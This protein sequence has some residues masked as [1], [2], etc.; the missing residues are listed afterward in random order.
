VNAQH[1]FQTY[2]ALSLDM[3]SQTK[4][5]NDTWP[6]I[7][8]EY[9][10][11]LVGEAIKNTGANFVG[12]TPLVKH[13]DRKA[14]EAYAYAN[15]GWM[16]DALE[17]TGNMGHELYPHT[18]VIDC[19]QGLAFDHNACPTKE[20]YAPVRHLAPILD[21]SEQIGFDA[22]SFSF[23]W[24]VYDGMIEEGE[25]VLSEIMN[26]GEEQPEWEREGQDDP[27][28]EP[29]SFMAAPIFRTR[30]QT[31][32]P[33][34]VLTAEM[35]WNSYFLNLLP[36][37]IDGIFLVVRNTCNQTFT[38]LIDGP[39]VT[40]LG[41]GDRHD[42]MFTS[43]RESD[44]FTTFVSVAECRYSFDVYPSDVF[45]KAYETDAPKENAAAV[46]IIFVLCVLVFVVYDFLVER[47]KKIL[48]VSAT[49]TGLLVNRCVV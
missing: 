34:G 44:N 27:I 37:D 35:P 28:E 24:R 38:Y 42:P 39:D 29:A 17:Y 23:F 33:V 26:L 31:G 45:K 14:Y 36:E 43:Y 20:L 22:F 8:F 40:F 15:Q 25:A 3:T 16:Q 49:K 12:F 41:V 18:K 48:M 32:E 5:K 30:D 13:K 1:I 2:K 7:T 19:L 10:E 47:R 21:M 46:N 9:Y 4:Y 11:S 6:F